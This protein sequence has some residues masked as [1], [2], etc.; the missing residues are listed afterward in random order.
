MDI[1]DAINPYLVFVLGVL[2]GLSTWTLKRVVQFGEWKAKHEG[3][4]KRTETMTER[5]FTDS[6]T[7]LDVAAQH[8]E[9]MNQI[10]TEI[11]KVTGMLDGFFRAFNDRF[12][13]IDGSL[14]KMQERCSAHLLALAENNDGTGSV[15]D[16]IGKS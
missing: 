11:T 4:A 5:A 10:R 16:R 2:V 9:E 8:G 1:F 3:L 15:D 7:A 13:V 6:Q 14:A 12:D